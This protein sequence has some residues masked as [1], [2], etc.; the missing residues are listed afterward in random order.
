MK[1]KT[2]GHELTDINCCEV[3]YP[4][5]TTVYANV[6]DIV[7]DVVTLPVAEYMKLKQDAATMKSHLDDAL[8]VL[9][10]IEIHANSA[11]TAVPEVSR[12]LG[13]VDPALS[14]HPI[15]VLNDQLCMIRSIYKSTL[16]RELLALR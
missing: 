5:D 15:H 2:C 16:V 12:A 9:W 4:P 14:G 8:R 10:R 13:P 3:C 6:P 1:C 11:S 7:K